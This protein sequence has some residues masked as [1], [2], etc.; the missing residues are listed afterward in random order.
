MNIL[1]KLFGWIGKLF[2]KIWEA[3]KKILPYI[4]LA[5]A[6]YLS[7]GGALTIP[8]TST[9]LQG[10]FHAMMV[11][12]ASFLLAPEETAELVSNAAHAIGDAASVVVSETVGVVTTGVGAL[13]TSPVGIAVMALGLWWLFG[14]DK[15]EGGEIPIQ[16]IERYEPIPGGDAL[17]ASA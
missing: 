15:K 3:I 10:T 9:V 13:L 17:R 8:F 7:L 4:L 12:G 16:Y 6:I 14:R 2:K 11:A 5:I 1:N